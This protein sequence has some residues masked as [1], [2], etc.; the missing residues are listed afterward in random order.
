[1]TAS[2]EDRDFVVTAVKQMWRFTHDRKRIAVATLD[3]CDHLGI[4]DPVDLVTNAFAESPKS[5]ARGST[6]GGA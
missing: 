1:V 3:L 5:Q 2:D 6:R 4:V